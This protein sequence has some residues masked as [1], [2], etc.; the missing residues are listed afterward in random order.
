MGFRCTSSTMV[1][2]VVVLGSTVPGNGESLDMRTVSQAATT[3]EADKT[4]KIEVKPLVP[5][6]SN[7]TQ[8]PAWRE[9]LQV[10]RERMRKRLAYDDTLYR[11]PD[12]AW[13]PSCYCCCFVMMCDKQF[14]DPA[15]RRFTVDA[16]VAEGLQRFS[17]Y[18]AVVLWHAYP[19]IGFDNRNQFDFYRDTPGGL[20]GLRELCR[21]LHDHGVKVFIDYNPWDTGTRPEGKPDADALVEL[22]QSVQADGIFLDTL[23]EGFA[24]IRTKLDTIRL[25]VVLESELTLPTQRIHD[26]HMSWA[27]WFDDSDVPGV[28]WNKW[29]ERRHM[30]HQ[31]KRWNHDHTGELHTA[32]MNGSG[33]LVWE[34]VF[35]TPVPWSGHNSSMLRSM[36]PIQRRYR[37]LFS[38]EQ[39][40]PL[41]ATQQAHVYASLWEGESLRLWTLVNRS[42]KIVEGALLKVPHLEE[43]RYYDLIAGREIRSIQGDYVLLEGKIA[44]YGIAAFVAGIRE[45][46]GPDFRDSLARQAALHAGPVRVDRTDSAQQSLKGPKPTKLYGPD[47]IPEDMVLIPAVEVDLEISYRNRECGFYHLVDGRLP[48]N[49]TNGLN[50]TITFKKP[51]RLG[52]FAIDLKP[53]TN[54]QFADFLEATGH[55]PAEAANFLKHWVTGRVPKGLEDHPVVYIDLDDARAYANWAGKRLPTEYEWQYA[56]QGADGRKYPWGNDWRD[57]FANAGRIGTTTP[58]TAFPNGRSPFGCYDMCGNTWEWTESERADARTHFCII[59]G[60]SFYKAEGS[61]WYTDGGPQPSNFAAKFLLSWPALDRCATIGFRCVVDVVESR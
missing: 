54:A 35:G 26:H 42:K 9:A 37:S 51:V 32:W 47:E 55:K 16:F 50:K 27:Q 3:T 25:G 46:L 22:I 31:I 11:R 20:P 19:R 5:A 24:E 49:P 28:L 52:P 7:P 14:Y 17:G 40:K 33:M 18:D 41:V 21:Q 56:A 59:R 13:V 58:V 23:H 10:E 39:W 29:F 53:V 43:Q 34:N 12:F 6:P 61:H 48:A 4:L 1:L 57:G 38:G 45:A 30:M 15:N 60:G 8:W 2:L 36:L 44:P